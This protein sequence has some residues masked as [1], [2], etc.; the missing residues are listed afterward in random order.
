[1][2]TPTAIEVYWAI[3]GGWR[4]LLSSIYLW[5]A[6][7]LTV[8]CYPLWATEDDSVRVWAQIALDIVP[9]MLGFSL[10]GMA[11]LL[12]ISSPNLLLV[13]RDG[14]KVDSLFMK[15]VSAFFHFIILQTIAI[16]IALVSKSYS[17]DII[18]AIGF[19]VMSYGTLVAVAVAGLLLNIARI[20]NATSVLD[21]KEDP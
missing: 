10:G 6:V 9:S 4:A 5:I 7:A 21:E 8:I 2:K 1:M 17:S 11:I 19:F 13:I 16:C 3:Y 20:F 12:A 18:S 15:T 14:G